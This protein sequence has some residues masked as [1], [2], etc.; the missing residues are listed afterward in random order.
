MGRTGE[1]RGLTTEQ[2]VRAEVVKEWRTGE[3]REGHKKRQEWV[4]E[5]ENR[6][7]KKQVKVEICRREDGR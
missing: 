4:M 2:V 5:K 6:L 3:R 7:E 1:E